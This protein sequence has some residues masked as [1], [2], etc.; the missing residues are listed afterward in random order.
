MGLG[1]F[2]KK[3][4]S[5][6]K[7]L[8]NK[9]ELNIPPPPPPPQKVS[10]EA[11]PSF[12]V[13]QENKVAPPIFNEDTTLPKPNVELNTADLSKVKQQFPDLEPFEIEEPLQLQKPT[14]TKPIEHIEIPHHKKEI[15]EVKHTLNRVQIQDGKPFYVNMD[16]YKQ[17]QEDI[18]VMSNRLTALDGTTNKIQAVRQKQDLEYKN[19]SSIFENMR[20]KLLFIDEV[21]FER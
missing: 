16:H 2:G 6:I 5:K 21:L 20:K 10:T 4:N 9:K 14:P 7:P 3:D 15:S 18:N 13:P 17:I 12:E 11:L 8:S 1:I 19:W